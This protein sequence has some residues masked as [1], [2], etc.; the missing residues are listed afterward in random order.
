MQMSPQRPSLL[1][2]FC[3]AGI[4]SRDITMISGS[5][6]SQLSGEGA[7]CAALINS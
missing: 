3:D 4:I 1:P 7:K 5:I 6:Q 2:S